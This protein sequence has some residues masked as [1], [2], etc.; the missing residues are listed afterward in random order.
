MDREA[1][2][3]GRPKGSSKFNMKP[4][5]S[6]SRTKSYLQSDDY[7]SEGSEE[8]YSDEEVYSQGAHEEEISSRRSGNDSNVSIFDLR[9][10]LK[11]IGH[12]SRARDTPAQPLRSSAS[13]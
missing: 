3:K 1:R 5:I 13:K 9:S 8:Y 12:R 7:D 2:P 4:I 10:K 11:T 6:T